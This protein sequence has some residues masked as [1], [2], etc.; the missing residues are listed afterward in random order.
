MPIGRML[1]TK[2]LSLFV[3]VV[4]CL[5]DVVRARHAHSNARFFARVL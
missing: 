5:L 4:E 2:L 3:G 1:P